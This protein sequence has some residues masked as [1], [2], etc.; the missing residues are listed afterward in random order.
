MNK[1]AHK[2]DRPAAECCLETLA[3][4]VEVSTT[5]RAVVFKNLLYVIVGFGMHISGADSLTR[6]YLVKTLQYVLSTV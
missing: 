5:A 1:S 2:C 6:V 3:R 4:L